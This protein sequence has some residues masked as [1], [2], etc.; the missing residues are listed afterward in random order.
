[1][2]KCNCGCGAEIP[3]KAACAW[4][5]GYGNPCKLPPEWVYFG[6]EAGDTFLCDGHDRLTVPELRKA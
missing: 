3:E 2:K 4:D 5:T 1:M 6:G